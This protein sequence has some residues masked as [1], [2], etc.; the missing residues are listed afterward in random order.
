MTALT[1]NLPDSEASRLRDVAR[2]LGKSAEE[3]VMDAVRD[4][5]RHSPA[6][7]FDAVAEKVV[8]KNAEL[9]RRLA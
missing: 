9:Y 5:I 2:D 4:R 8:E 7:D 6:A 3:V 1:I